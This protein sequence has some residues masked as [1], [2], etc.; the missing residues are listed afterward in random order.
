MTTASSSAS[1]TSARPLAGQAAFVTGGSRGIGAAIVRRLA[2]DGA[3]V[4]F[5]YSAAQAQA[6]AL[7]RDIQAEGGRARALR[8]DSADAAA[9][10]AGIDEAAREFGRL[11]ILVNNA[12]V[13][14]LGSVDTFSLEDL[15]RTLA[16]N[17][18]AVYVGAQAAARHMGTGGRIVNIGSTNAD[19]MPFAGGSAYAMSKAALK[20][21]VQGMARDLGPRGITINNV[22]PGPIDTEMNPADGEMAEGVRSFMA[23]P[24]YGHTDDI[25]GMV[26]YLVGPEGGFVTGA[27]LNIDGGFA[28]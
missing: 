3:A 4:A 17:V 21:L 11:D 22:Q 9:L 5:S 7:V 24:H 18:R 15:D 19:R 27:S 28:A 16:V 10:Q 8:I 12:G 26:A 23:L 2:R 14:R 6:D 13:L 1:S 20:G 25:A